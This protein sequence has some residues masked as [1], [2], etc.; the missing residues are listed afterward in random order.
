M[1]NKVFPWQE[2]LWK[3][4]MLAPEQLPHALLLMGPAG[5]GKQQFALA[6]AARLLCEQAQ[7][8]TAAA[9]ACG[10]CNACQWLAN[11]QH[12]D[13]RLVQPEAEDGEGASSEDGGGNSTASTN[14]SATG[15]RG[16]RKEPAIAEAAT[17]HPLV[18]GEV[19][20]GP[21]RIDQIRALNDFVYTASHRAGRRV[22]V[23]HPAEMMNPAAANALL[24]ILEEPPAG[25]YFI[26]VANAW[27]K[28]LPTI[29]S[30]CRQL[31]MGRPS[32]QEVQAWLALQGSARL[33]TGGKAQGSGQ[34]TAADLL[35]LAG[36]APLLALRWSEQGRLDLLR[37][38]IAPLESAPFDPVAMAA[39]WAGLLKGE[40]ALS[41]AQIVD[42]LQKW[43]YDL[44]QLRRV[45]KRAP[46]YHLAWQT[47]LNKLAPQA[48]EVSLFA[49]YQELLRL[50]A[51]ARHPL[52]S[53]LFLEDLAARYCRI[54]NKQ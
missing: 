22:V 50:Q 18:L 29:R 51:V 2:R 6:L 19:S 42:T 5:I 54:F 21:I 36:G 52:N 1:I 16:G 34:G 47:S 8:S 24:K 32:S 17:H 40:M 31:S 33:A 46:H 14:K 38:I 39:S 4:L 37:R 12:P 35:P 11:G 7:V 9:L 44:V 3:Q 28:L 53:Q 48:D 45:S 15:K 43:I 13:F 23:V 10:Q 26:L 20:Q 25:V 30:R 41:L 27:R 49:A